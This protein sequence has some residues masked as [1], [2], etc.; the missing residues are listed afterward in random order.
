MRLAL[1][2]QSIGKG[3]GRTHYDVLQHLFCEASIFS[4][5][6]G[7]FIIAVAAVCLDEVPHAIEVSLRAPSFRDVTHKRAS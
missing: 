5:R 7:L 2:P 4:D 6:T 1:A 3:L